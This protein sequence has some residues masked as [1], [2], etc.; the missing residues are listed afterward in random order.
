MG[1]ITQLRG[2]FACFQGG[3]GGSGKRGP[4]TV[5][6]ETVVGDAHDRNVVPFFEDSARRKRVRSVRAML[7]EDGWWCGRV[8]RAVGATQRTRV[9]SKRPLLG[10]WSAEHVAARGRVGVHG[11][12]ETDGAFGTVAAFG[13]PKVLRGAMVA[14]PV[15][16]WSMRHGG[17][18]D[19]NRRTRPYVVLSFFLLGVTF[20]KPAFES[21]VRNRTRVFLCF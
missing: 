19:T 17:W 21:L 4:T 11:P 5:D 14:F 2:H 16:G 8:E 7:L 20:P 18:C 10:A 1:W 15:V 12:F 3:G 6:V 9:G 13:A